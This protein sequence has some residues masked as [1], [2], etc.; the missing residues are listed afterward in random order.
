MHMHWLTAEIGQWDIRYWLSKLVPIR[1]RSVYGVSDG[2]QRW[3][4]RAVWWQW[5]DRVYRVHTEVCT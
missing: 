1:M 2:T 3:G 4:E 5:R